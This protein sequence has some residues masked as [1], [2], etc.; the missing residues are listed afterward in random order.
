MKKY[1][2]IYADPPWRYNNPKRNDPAMGGITY[3]V[4]SD[5]DICNLPIVSIV[6]ENCSLFLWAT[7]PKLTEALVVIKAWGFVYTTCVRTN[8]LHCIHSSQVIRSP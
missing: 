8:H 5:E 3:P 2:I 6:D 1:Q 4:L 7:M